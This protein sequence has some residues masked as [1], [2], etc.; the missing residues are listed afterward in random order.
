MDGSTWPV[1]AAFS[2]VE[3]LGP[4]LSSTTLAGLTRPLVVERKASGE[5]EIDAEERRSMPRLRTVYRIAKV[6]R[7]RASGL[8]RVRNISDF[9]MMM[10]T[11]VQPEKGEK[12]SIALSDSVSIEGQVVWCRNDAC[13]V[14]FEQP[15]DSAAL[16]KKLAADQADSRSRAPRISADMAAAAWCES[17]IQP[18]RIDDLSQNG[19]G[20]THDGW[21]RPGMKLLVMLEGGIERRGIVRWSDESNAG[22]QLLDPLACGDLEQLGI[23]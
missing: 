16:L 15:I 6:M 12:L 18:I 21:V 9:G 19:I 22:L 4:R 13:G 5:E 11:R 10:L 3:T 23:A 1:D 14:R 8:W 7:E 20:F 2:P 17:G